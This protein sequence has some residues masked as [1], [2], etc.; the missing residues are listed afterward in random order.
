MDLLQEESERAIFS[1]KFDSAITIIGI[2]SWVI[3]CALLALAIGTIFWACLGTI[4]L[5]VTGKCLVFN[6]HNV[7]SLRSESSWV[8]KQILAVGGDKIEKGKTLVVF[9]GSGGPAGL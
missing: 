9:E 1:E 6:P 8:V 5:T 3:L 4:P 2:K 7:I